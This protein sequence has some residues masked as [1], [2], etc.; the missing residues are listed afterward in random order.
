MSSPQP[1][2]SRH[3][4]SVGTARNDTTRHGTARTARYDV[5]WFGTARYGAVRFD[6]TWYDAVRY[7]KAQHMGAF[8]YRKGRIKTIFGGGRFNPM[9]ILH[10]GVATGGDGGTPSPAGVRVG[11]IIPS[12]NQMSIEVFELLF[13][14]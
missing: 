13:I 11:G 7:D 5:T 10:M 1:I 4:R 9:S 2:T 14:S 6:T 12:S 3:L 8:S